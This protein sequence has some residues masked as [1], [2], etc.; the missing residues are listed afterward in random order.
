M[1]A[2][3]TEEKERNIYSAEMETKYNIFQKN[4]TILRIEN[5]KEQAQEQRNATIFFLIVLTILVIA[6]IVYQIKLN[7]S[8]K[9]F[10]V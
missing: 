1:R 7:K 8:N 10:N 9:K 2:S 3:F 4:N 5:E 6:L